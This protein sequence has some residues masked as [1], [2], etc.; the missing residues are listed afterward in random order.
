VETITRTTSNT[1]NHDHFVV[2]W[3]ADLIQVW[4]E[5]DRSIV[6]VHPTPHHTEDEILAAALEICGSVSP[7]ALLAVLHRSLSFGEHRLAS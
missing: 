5:E 4:P 6:S 3:A 7:A 1:S 2:G